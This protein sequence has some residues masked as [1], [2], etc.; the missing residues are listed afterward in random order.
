LQNNVIPD[1]LVTGFA[2]QERDAVDRIRQYIKDYPPS[3]PSIAMFKNGKLIYFM[4]RYNI[5]GR[6]GEEIAADLKGAFDELCTKQGPS[7]PPDA[8]EK[9]TYAVQCGSKIP[10][11]KG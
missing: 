3:S 4:Q 1:R 10:L 9:V 7:I 11:Y 6:S 2:G 5:E 8:F